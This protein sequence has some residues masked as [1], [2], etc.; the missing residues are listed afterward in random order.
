MLGAE[1]CPLHPPF[2]FLQPLALCEVATQRL[3][4]NPALGRKVWALCDCRWRVCS[5]S[6]VSDERGS[7]A[8]RAWLNLYVAFLRAAAHARMAALSAAPVLSCWWQM[9][10]GFVSL[11]GRRISSIFLTLAGQNLAL[12][13]WCSFVVAVV[14]SLFW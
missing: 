4:V 8:L 13:C 1:L 7:F 6:T 11:A 9:H 10:H 12:V 14:A 3:I 5:F 2:L